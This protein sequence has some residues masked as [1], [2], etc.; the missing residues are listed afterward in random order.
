MKSKLSWSKVTLLLRERIHTDVYYAFGFASLA[1][2]PQ[3][4]SKDQE[5]IK[6]LSKDK[7]GKKEE[8]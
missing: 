2:L 4:Q 7:D 3:R 8:I 6:H 1:D 5:K